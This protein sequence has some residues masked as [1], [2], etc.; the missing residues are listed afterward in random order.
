MLIK[1]LNNFNLKQWVIENKIHLIVIAALTL[2]TYANAVDNE[3]LS[4]DIRAIVNNQNITDFNSYVSFKNFHFIRP[5]IYYIIVQVFGRNPVPFHLLNISFHLGTALTVY[6]LISL[7]H[8]KQTAFFSSLL[9]GVHPILTEAVTWISGN[10]YILYT[11]FALLSFLFF[12]FSYK[13]K[14][15]I[16]LSI[17]SFLTAYNCMERAISL[18]FILISFIIFWPKIKLNR[19]LKPLFI[20][21]VVI[22]LGLT[23]YTVRF[24]PQRLHSLKT[25]FYQNPQ[26]LNPLEQIP[27]AVGK[28]LELIVWPKQLTLYHSEINLINQRQFIIKAVE[29]GIFFAVGIYFFFKNK[30]IFFW[31]TFIGLALGPMLTPFGIS[32][33]VAERYV[34]FASIGFFTLFALLIDY[35]N[36]IPKLNKIPF[37]VFIT[38]IIP[39]LSLRT[40]VRNN[41]W[42]NQDRL[43]LSAAKY[44]PHSSQNQNNL[45]DLYARHGNFEKSIFHFQKAIE[46]RPGYADAYHNMANIYWRLNQTDIAIKHYEKAEELNPKIWQTHQNLGILY[47]QTGQTEKA[48]DQLKKAIELNQTSPNLYA[49]LAKMYAKMGE[50]EKAQ[51]AAIKSQQLSNQ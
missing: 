29:F 14:Y 51:E 7:L 18:P 1:R 12:I 8:N 50:E 25:N 17:L 32:W 48:L 2:I 44:S 5:L 15:F 11:F 3:F 43:W 42:Q 46:I 22:G 9:F 36:K 20:G 37:T 41:V 30:K 45:G 34:Y 16:Y 26:M 35:L 27:T 24:I 13:K 39:L 33:L 49:N 23:A 19:Q 6:L 47:F 28:Y 40:I 10:P 31:F 21:L 4:D 38:I